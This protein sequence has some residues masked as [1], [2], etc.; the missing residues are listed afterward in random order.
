MWASSPRLR[1]T[2]IRRH[3]KS[4]GIS[5]IF[6]YFS[7][8]K[9]VFLAHTPAAAVAAGEAAVSGLVDVA[10]TSEEDA[11]LDELLGTVEVSRR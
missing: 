1:T 6:R 10:G 2:D 7:Y 8:K 9:W 11:L 3:S 5:S 4:N